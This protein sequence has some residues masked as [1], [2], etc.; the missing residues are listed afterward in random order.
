MGF[1]PTDIDGWEP[2]QFAAAWKGWRAAN[3]PAPGPSA[4]SDDEFRKAVEG[5]MS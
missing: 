2:Y 1:S 3:L 5:A 4:P